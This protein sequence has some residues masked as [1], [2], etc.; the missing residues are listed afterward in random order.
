MMRL[1]GNCVCDV[2]RGSGAVGVGMKVLC[3]KGDGSCVY[4]LSRKRCCERRQVLCAGEKGGGAG[5]DSTALPHSNLSPNVMGEQRRQ[6]ELG[7]VN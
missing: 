7:K 5:G 3:G 2:G 4:A 6:R 1:G